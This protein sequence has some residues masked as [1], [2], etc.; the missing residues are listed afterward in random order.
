MEHNDKKPGEQRLEI[1]IDDAVAQGNYSNLAIINHNDSEFTLDFAYLQP[2]APQGK[3][4]ARV[5]T[6][7]RHAK[8]LLLALEE[9]LRKYEASFGPI[10]LGPKGVGPDVAPYH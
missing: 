9:N 5:I 3:V 1:Q 6:S 8:R 7:P 4:R 10:D 2:Q